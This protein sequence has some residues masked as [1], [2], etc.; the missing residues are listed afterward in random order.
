MW[1]TLGIVYFCSKQIKK[2]KLL[3]AYWTKTW[4]EPCLPN[5]NLWALSYAY[6]SYTDTQIFVDYHK[7][8]TNK[9]CK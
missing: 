4:H 7:N 6:N 5:K 1:Q 2:K 9:A 3:P 8:C